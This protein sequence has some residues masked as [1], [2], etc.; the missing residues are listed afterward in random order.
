[1]IAQVGDTAQQ[2][3]KG[4]A[5]SGSQTTSLSDQGDTDTPNVQPEHLDSRQSP[6]KC[7]PGTLALQECCLERGSEEN[8]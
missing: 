8:Q 1:M 6:Q 7:T 5:T 2:T 4:G 3:G